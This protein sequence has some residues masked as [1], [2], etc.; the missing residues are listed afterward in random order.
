MIAR[1]PWSGI[2]SRPVM[3][4]QRLRIT[5]VKPV[6]IKTSSAIYLLSAHSLPDI[7]MIV[8]RNSQ[9]AKARN[10]LGGVSLIHGP[11]KFSVMYIEIPANSSKPLGTPWP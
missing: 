9:Y 2:N 6:V 11:K 8:L 3:N 7:A 1:D 4:E 10:F 5:K